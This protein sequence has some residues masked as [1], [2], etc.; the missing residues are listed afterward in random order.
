MNAVNVLVVFILTE[1]KK[2][3]EIIFRDL[4]IVNGPYKT[5]TEQHKNT[6]NTKT[7]QTFRNEKKFFFYI[8]LQFLK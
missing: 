4:F 6:Q 5:N 8:Y 3:L 7:Q 1:N 2:R